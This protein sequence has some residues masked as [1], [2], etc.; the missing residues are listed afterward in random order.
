MIAERSMTVA[1][2]YDQLAGACCSFFPTPSRAPDLFSAA[3]LRVPAAVALYR[4]GSRCQFVSGGLLRGHWRLYL[5]AANQEPCL[6]RKRRAGQPPPPYP[7]T[8]LTRRI[9]VRIQKKIP[10]NQ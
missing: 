7:C 6:E 1:C 9:C 5:V 3:R 10:A 2:T 8:L 4:P